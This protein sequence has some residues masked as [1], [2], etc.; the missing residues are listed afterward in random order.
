M[1]ATSEDM[2]LMTVGDA[3]KIL[4]GQRYAERQ[5]E[6]RLAMKRAKTPDEIEREK[7]RKEVEK[8][9][10]ENPSEVARLVRTWLAEEQ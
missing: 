5:A 2:S 10:N 8:Y 9:S 7:I 3:E 4:A 1:L 6:L